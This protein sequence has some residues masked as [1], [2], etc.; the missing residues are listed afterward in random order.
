MSRP[1]S[2]FVLSLKAFRDRLVEARRAAAR[3]PDLALAMR[4][5]TDIEQTIALVD[6]AIDNE[7]D[8]T[9]L[10]GIDDPTEP[11]PFADSD[12]GPPVVERL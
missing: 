6:R 4:R 9:P 8:L 11:P 1:D 5:F 7:R 2:P 12:R 3:E 10:P